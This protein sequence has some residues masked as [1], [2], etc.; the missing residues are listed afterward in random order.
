MSEFKNGGL[1][2]YG[3]EPLERQQF[4][5]AGVEGVN[6]TTVHNNTA[7]TKTA[8][9]TPDSARFNIYVYERQRPGGKT[10]FLGGGVRAVDPMSPQPVAICLA[11]T[12]TS[13][14]N[15]TSCDNLLLI[16]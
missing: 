4:E 10:C 9:R 6:N 11:Q 7:N 13:I 14:H 2:Q 16:H 5:R 12:V 3:T 1:D 15:I 8:V